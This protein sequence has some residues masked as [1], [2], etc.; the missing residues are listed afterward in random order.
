MKSEAFGRLL[1]A[2]IGSIAYCEGKTAPVIEEDLGHQVGVAPASI[3][4]YKAGHV[5]PDPHTVEKLA[6]ACV[7]RGL[8]GRE[9]LQ[10]F[11]HAGRYPAPEMLIAKLISTGTARQ[12]APRAY[13]NLPAPTYSQFVMR[14]RAFAE[15]IDGLQQRS[16]AVL[17]VGLGGNGKT[18]LAREV[19]DRC[20]RGADEV[21][22]FDAVVW[23]SDKDQPGTTNLS[24]VLDAV[25][26]TLDYPGLTRYAHNEKRYEVEQLL[27]RQHVLLV[28]DNFE[29]V[30]DGALLTWLL[31]LPEPSKAIVTSREYS[32]AFRNNTF[33]LDLRGMSDAE[34]LIF[35]EQRLRF[36]RIDKL[37][38]DPGYLDSL[39]AV[40]R[41]N[42]KAIEMVLGLVKYEHR[43]LQQ[44]VD[45]LFAARGEL[46]DDLF[47][48]AWTLLDDAA[49]RILLIMTFFP[50]SASSE[51]LSTTADVQGLA[52]AKAAERLLDLAL[53]DIQQEDLHSASRYTLHPLVRAFAAARLAVQP[54]LERGARERWVQWYIELV[55]GVGYC[56]D[57][58]GRLESFDLEHESI[59]TVLTWTFQ[60]GYFPATLQ[61]AKGCSYY[62]YTRG[63]WDKSP[64]VNVTGAM[65]AKYLERAADHVEMLAYHVQML[66]IQGNLL[67]AAQYLPTLRA[68]AESTSLPADIFLAYQHAIAM[69]RLTRGELEAAEQAWRESLHQAGQVATPVRDVN[70]RWLAT[71]LYLQGKLEAAQKLF[72]ET[73]TE[74]TQRGYLRG[75]MFCKVRL[76]AIYL[77][78]GEITRAEAELAESSALAEQYHIRGAITDALRVRARVYFLRG[79]LAAAQDALTKA[80]ELYERLGRRR[81][82]AEA[83]DELGRLVA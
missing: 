10:Q 68:L 78:Q 37:V 14:E 6:G 50:A 71:C 25:A 48:R 63:F 17:I 33:V 70:R 72:Q 67:E 79:D 22:H 15:V 62:L 41:G 7:K 82:L 64:S 52:L 55:A 39:V 53:L 23:V 16:A 20:L 34:A 66:S 56:W 73:L 74:A 69:Y 2:G 80:I 11:L 81:E 77:D 31:R 65:A 58:L 3:Q 51:A 83:R 45:D 24:V 44:V 47:T 54:E 36:L 5:P 9:W 29:T 28:I 12:N 1:K 19:A 8:M 26:R 4:R 30:T 43:P 40:T 46:F 59:Y 61:L 38:S 60:N 57:N 13:E 75:I 42:P 49:Q 76:A 18:S 35:I 21:P 27:R 32:R